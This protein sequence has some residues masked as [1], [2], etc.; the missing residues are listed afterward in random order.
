MALRKPPPPSGHKLRVTYQAS[1]GRPG[2]GRTRSRGQRTQ[3]PVEFTD[4]RSRSTLCSVKGLRA[5]PTAVGV[6]G[7]EAALSWRL[8]P[9][10]LG[11][12][13]GPWGRLSTVNKVF[14][15]YVKNH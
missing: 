8:S 13:R 3:A 14:V 5:H 2:T 15:L 10:C 12:P 11:R 9:G 4:D 1:Q 7:S 6:R